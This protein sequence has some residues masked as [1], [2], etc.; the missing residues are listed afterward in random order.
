MDFLYSNIKGKI[1]MKLTIKQKHNI[2]AKI[3][4]EYDYMDKLPMKG[5]AWEF[6]RRNKEYIDAFRKLEKVAKPDVWNDKCDT[7]LSELKSIIIPSG[8]FIGRMSLTVN[9]TVTR[10]YLALKLPPYK[11][12]K[13][14]YNKYFRSDHHVCVVLRPEKRYCDMIGS[15]FFPYQIPDY[16]IYKSFDVLLNERMTVTMSPDGKNLIQK[17]SADR[18]NDVFYVAVSKKANIADLKEC[19]IADIAKILAKQNKHKPKIRKNKWKYYLI[20]YDLMQRFNG[21]TPYDDIGNI[22]I[23]A[24]PEEKK[25]QYF[26]ETKNINNWHDKAVPL[27]NGGFIKYLKKQYP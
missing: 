4:D 2:A 15:L 22:L 3:P 21:E 19:M 13:A 8:L 18:S 10:N 7:I 11:G 9:K 26:T 25:T 20:V 24:Y 1:K 23:Y 5:W 17:P 12:N 16:K 27:I 14:S 6:L